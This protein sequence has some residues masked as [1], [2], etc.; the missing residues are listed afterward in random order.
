MT[1]AVL[2]FVGLGQMGSPMAT[3]IAAA[4]FELVAFDAAGTDERLAAGA[5]AAAGVAELAQRA[6]T[7][8]LSLPDGDASFAVAG[9]V[10]ATAGR[11]VRTVIDLS[12]VGPAVAADV[13]E[14]LGPVGVTYADGPVSGGV[15]GARAGTI[16]LMYAGPTAVLN[17]HRAV[18]DSFARVFPVGTTPGQG[19]TMKLVNNFLSAVALA[20]TSEALALGL[21]HGLDMSVMLDVL[22]ASTGRN[23]A[24]VDKFPNRIA[25]GTFDAGFRTALMAKDLRLH[26]AAAGGAGTANAIGSVVS[27]VWQRADGALPESD[28]TRIWEFVTSRSRT[29]A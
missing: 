25:T 2:G 29:V 26:Q 22:N 24:T 28:F 13:A 21:A 9:E 7:L 14:L 1:P 18:L 4:G 5:T 19:Q 23:S 11:R 8:L 27:D 6:D 17:D 15:A 12:T 16:S 20:A 3:R 10:V